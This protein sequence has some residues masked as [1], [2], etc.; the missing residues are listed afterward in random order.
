MVLTAQAEGEIAMVATTEGG[1]LGKVV[2]LSP[3]VGIGVESAIEK[4]GVV[5]EEED[6]WGSAGG[7]KGDGERG[8][9]GGRVGGNG[10][11]GKG[12]GGGGG[13]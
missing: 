6:F 11:G 7:E 13:G 10:G 1:Q 3:G 12:E 4:E 2:D 9:G 5:K 8:E